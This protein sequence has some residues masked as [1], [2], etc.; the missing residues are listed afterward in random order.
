MQGSISTLSQCLRSNYCFKFAYR[1]KLRTVFHV[2]GAEIAR[3]TVLRRGAGC[4]VR[5]VGRGRRG[6]AHRVHGR[7][8]RR[9]AAAARPEALARLWS[10]FNTVSVNA[11][12]TRVVVGSTGARMLTFN[13]H[14]H[15]AG[16]LLTYR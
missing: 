12:L 1:A 13:E 9:D 2:A 3:P 10:S 16:E 4:G 8:H 5:S 6:D 11:G 14:S 7:R 15:V